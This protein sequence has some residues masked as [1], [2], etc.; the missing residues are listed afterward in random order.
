M[1]AMIACYDLSTDINSHDHYHWLIVVAGMGAREIVY[2]T[3]KGFRA[4][5]WPD[6]QTAE[7]YC[8]IVRPAA[9]FA[10]L[11]SRDGVD[12]TR[13]A[14][15]HK[16]KNAHKWALNHPRAV[17][18][19][20]SILPPGDKRDTITLRE[21]ILVD[22]LRNS[23]IKAWLDFADKIGAHVIRD[24]LVEPISMAQ[25]LALYAGAEMNFGVDNGPMSVCQMTPYPCMVFK[26]HLNEHYLFRCGL[27]WHGKF[28]WCSKNQFMFWEDDT[29]ANIWAR[30]EQWHGRR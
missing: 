30:F 21:Q 13:I 12:G 18:K 24:Y 15:L 14:G 1:T 2:D 26:Y 11:P 8:T 27:K 3:S 17:A 25:R 4:S 20:K 29:P 19:L 22:P 9:A 6:D 16:L 10:G 28:V 7:R 23:N 5:R